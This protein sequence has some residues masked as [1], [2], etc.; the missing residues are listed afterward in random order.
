M[1]DGLTHFR[2][3]V[4]G[5]ALAVALAAAYADPGTTR[6]VLVGSAIG[7]LVTPD[8]DQAS[9]TFTE[10]LIGR[11]P[12]VGRLFRLGWQGYAQLF[13]HRGLSHHL[14]IGTG[15][16]IVWSALIFSVGSLTALGLLRCWDGIPRNWID[17]C[18]RPLLS[19]AHS[20]ILLGWWLQDALHILADRL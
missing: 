4:G 3:G 18:V 20:G 9:V 13:R 17:V 6:A 7:L 2:I 19:Q 5:G 12:V 14:L 16:R 10:R 8:L 11:V 1:P 15:T